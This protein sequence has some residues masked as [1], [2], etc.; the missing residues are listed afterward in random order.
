VYCTPPELDSGATSPHKK[1]GKYRLAHRSLGSLVAFLETVEIESIV[2]DTPPSDCLGC[3]C[4]PA[5]MLREE[6]H[7]RWLPTVP[8]TKLG[9]GSFAGDPAIVVEAKG[10]TRIYVNPRSIERLKPIREARIKD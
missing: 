8:E 5:K 9:A 10:Q 1:G 7:M 6:D 4:P 3:A 2:F